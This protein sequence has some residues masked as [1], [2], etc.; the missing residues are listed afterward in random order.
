[1]GAAAAFA[2][3]GKTVADT[4]GFLE[5]VNGLAGLKPF[6]VARRF[7]ERLPGWSQASVRSLKRSATSKK[8]DLSFPIH[9]NP[10]EA[11]KERALCQLFY[12]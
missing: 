6:R 7:S 10:A 1:V 9:Q 11:E 8:A 5:V 3:G 4:E 2:E 12:G